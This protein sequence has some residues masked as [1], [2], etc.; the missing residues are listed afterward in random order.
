[1]L[2]YKYNLKLLLGIY[3]QSSLFIGT[4]IQLLTINY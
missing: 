1:M 4:I 2:T 3:N